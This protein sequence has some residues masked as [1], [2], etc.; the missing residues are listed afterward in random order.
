MPCLSLAGFIYALYEIWVREVDKDDNC[1]FTEWG[2]SASDILSTMNAA[3]YV[4]TYFILL[5]FNGKN[6]TVF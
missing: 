2:E 3:V 4:G 5:S 1:S 6:D